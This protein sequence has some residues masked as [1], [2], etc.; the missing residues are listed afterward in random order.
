MLFLLLRLG[1]ES[2]APRLLTHS[3]CCAQVLCEHGE[4]P[5]QLFLED[6][7]RRAVGECFEDLLT[8]EESATSVGSV[9]SLLL[10]RI[11]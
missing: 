9:D 3:W 6:F 11:Q 8:P 5:D 2:A 4:E 7:L 10:L 1:Q